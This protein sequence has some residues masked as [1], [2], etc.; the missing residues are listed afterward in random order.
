MKRL[1]PM[2][3]FYL[4]LFVGPIVAQRVLPPT[5]A[6]NGWMQKAG[7]QDVP[8]IAT[9]AVLVGVTVDGNAGVS[10][11]AA[12]GELHLYF[13]PDVAKP[14]EPIRL[15]LDLPDGEFVTLEWGDDAAEKPEFDFG[16]E[17][18][19]ENR[20]YV[21]PVKADHAVKVTGYWVRDKKIKRKS[22]TATLHI[23]EP[24]KLAEL[25]TKEVAD[26]LA[27]MYR[28]MLAADFSYPTPAAFWTGHAKGLEEYGVTDHAA[29]GEIAKR[30]TEAI[31]KG[32]GE[33]N[34]EALTECLTTIIVDLGADPTPKPNPPGP[35][36]PLAALIPDPA[37]RALIAE[38][39]A[40]MAGV[41]REGGAA[42]VADFYAA[43]RRAVDAAQANGKLPKGLAAINKPISDRI[44][45]A[46]GGTENTPIDA[47][48]RAALAAALDGIA[49]EF[50]GS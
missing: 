22:V 5:D 8:T 4:A 31:G 1:A 38:F 7:A 39:Y 28:S 11:K 21:W 17:G 34:R 43:Q 23:G 26:K 49:A 20:W 47:T 42:T 18:C 37:H 41:V 32:E 25:V 6:Q 3:V 12:D 16:T 44:T 40:D 50:R 30:I 15:Y 48:K 29:T 33:I 19:G 2:C 14:G 10:E 36:S 35:L 13:K 9:P 27:Q 46:L 45:A 24:K